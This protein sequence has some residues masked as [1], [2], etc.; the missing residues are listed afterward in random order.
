MKM[1]KFLSIA[2][3]VLALVGFFDATYLTAEHYMGGVP[4]CFIA[5]GCEQVTT[6]SYSVILGVPV[7]LLGALYYLVLFVLGV[8][9]LGEYKKMN[10]NLLFLISSLGFLSS[11]YFV[12]LQLFV[13]NAI[14]AY[15]MIS[16]L[17]TTL[18]LLSVLSLRWFNKSEQNEQQP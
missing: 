6:S 13:I 4:P 16:A 11:I 18:I 5:T 2:I 10:Q 8:N 1:K 14:C 3:V 12:A 17:T 7:A 9:G 15:C